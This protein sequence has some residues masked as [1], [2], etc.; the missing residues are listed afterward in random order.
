MQIRDETS[1]DHCRPAE[2]NRDDWRP[3]GNTADRKKL[4]NKKA[5]VG[6]DRYHW[7]ALETSGD[8]SRPTETTDAQQKQ[9]ETCRDHLR[10]LDTI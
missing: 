4:V 9:L 6:G 8:Q 2:S 5:I 1:A 3:L 7:R 10:R